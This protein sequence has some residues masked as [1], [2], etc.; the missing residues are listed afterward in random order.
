[1]G[2]PPRTVTRQ[3]LAHGACLAVPLHVW[4]LHADAS[5]VRRL[6]GAFLPIAFGIPDCRTAVDASGGWRLCGRVAGPTTRTHAEASLAQLSSVVAAGHGITPSDIDSVPK[7]FPLLLKVCSTRVAPSE[8]QARAISHHRGGFESTPGFFTP[9]LKQT[10]C[11][12]PIRT[13]VAELIA[14]TSTTARLSS[15]QALLALHAQIPPPGQAAG[16]LDSGCSGVMRG[17][18]NRAAR[19][20]A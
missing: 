17:H 8:L 1:M 9:G 12:Q 4:L 16:L 18:R 13:A 20:H 14:R 11:M 5:I 19:P 10:D 15:L 2:L 6:L 3:A 7:Y